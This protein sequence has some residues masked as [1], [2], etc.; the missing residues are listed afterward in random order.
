MFVRIE[1]S[2]EPDFYL[3]TDELGHY[4][5]RVNGFDFAECIVKDREI[6]EDNHLYWFVEKECLEKYLLK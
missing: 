6:D 2:S 1:N 5:G 4:L 3:V